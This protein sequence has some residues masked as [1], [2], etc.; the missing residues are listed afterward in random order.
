M[1]L[2][3][4]A[5]LIVAALLFGIGIYTVVAQRSAVMVLMGVELLLNAIG[6]NLIAFWR[7]VRPDDYSGQIFTILIVTVGAIEMAVGLAI[8]MLLYRNRQTQQVDDYQ[9]LKG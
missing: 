3:L 7:Y 2:P 1:T 5:Y 8:M 9:E 6:L 4:S